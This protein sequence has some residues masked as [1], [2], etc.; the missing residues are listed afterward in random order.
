MFITQHKP[1]IR[2]FIYGTMG[3]LK[4]K[5]NMRAL[6]K[7]KSGI[8]VFCKYLIGISSLTALSWIVCFSLASSFIDVYMPITMH[9]SEEIQ[10]WRTFPITVAHFGAAT[11]L[12]TTVLVVLFYLRKMNKIVLNRQE[13]MQGNV[14]PEQTY[15]EAMKELVKFKKKA[16]IST[17][18]AETVR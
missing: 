15:A 18:P 7:I 14:N 17:E 11:S 9:S 8:V 3:F 16:P 4:T 6:L 10:F 5:L 2:A 13:T 1:N 12:V